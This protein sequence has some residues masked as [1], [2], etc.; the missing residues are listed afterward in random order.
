MN[1][2]P[3]SLA[4]WDTPAFETVFKTE[5]PTLGNAL[6]LQEN[7]TAGSYAVENS[8]EVMIISKTADDGFIR[9][10]TGLFYTS[11]MPG[12]ACAGDPTVEDT[13]NEH[14]TILVSI[15]R[16]TGAAIFETLKNE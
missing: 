13:Q 14:A 15:N 8:V 16:E 2:L 11:L 9:V 7:L 6:P 12:C 1:T 4:A 10:K 3:K 5:L